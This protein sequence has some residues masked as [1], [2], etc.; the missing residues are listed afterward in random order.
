MPCTRK[1]N[2]YTTDLFFRTGYWITQRLPITT[3]LQLLCAPQS[4]RRAP[5]YEFEICRRYAHLKRWLTGFV[6]VCFDT[7]E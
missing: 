3:Y 2:E 5:T 6:E 4:N 1:V 7:V